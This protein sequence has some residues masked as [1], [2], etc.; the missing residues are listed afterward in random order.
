[1]ALRD[2]FKNKTALVTGAGSGIGAAIARALDAQ[3]AIVHCADIDGAAAEQTARALSRA[4]AHTLDVTDAPAMEALAERLYA[5]NG[6]IDLLFNNAGIGHAGAV[7]DCTLDDWRAMLD[8]NVMGVVHGVHVFLP[9]MLAQAGPAHIVNTASGAGLIPLPGMAPYCAAKHAVVGLSQ[10]L[11]SE[12]HDS[13]IQ[14]TILCPGTIN[15]NIV[16]R[17]Q[18]RGQQAAKQQAKAVRHYKKH[19]ASPDDVA[20]DLLTDIHKKRM[21]CVTPRREVGFGWLAQRLS[22]A[23]TQRMLRLRMSSI[24][25]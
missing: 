20:A 23:L 5:D 18:M 1:M 15:T 8:V 9:R 25:D 13:N 2:T 12:L 16:K 24:M 4:T 3:G 22:P 11:A 21:I 17:T 10:S 19:G 7:V 14:V 6:H